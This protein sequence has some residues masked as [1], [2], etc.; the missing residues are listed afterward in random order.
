M[1]PHI[2]TEWK[3]CSSAPSKPSRA[4]LTPLLEDARLSW[5]SEHEERHDFLTRILGGAWTKKHKSVSSDAIA[6]FA[7]GSVP[8]AWA[9]EYGLDHMNSFAFRKYGKEAASA[10][11]LEWC[12]RMQYFFDIWQ[13][14]EDPDYCYTKSDIDGYEES[15]EW[16]NWML[17][18]ADDA[19]HILDRA[20]KMRNMRPSIDAWT[21]NGL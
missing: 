16:I 5:E 2:S 19:H 20:R 21:Y 1:P 10:L 4:I 3:V 14:Q 9:V 6:G 13:W 7:K 12:S 17:N 15:L 18:I 11:A 8:K